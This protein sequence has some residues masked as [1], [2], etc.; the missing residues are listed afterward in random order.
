M[1]LLGHFFHPG[2]PRL[3][4]SLSGPPLHPTLV[5]YTLGAPRRLLESKA[6][7]RESARSAH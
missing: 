2:K 7:A 4:N 5:T 3:Q 1:K 6:V